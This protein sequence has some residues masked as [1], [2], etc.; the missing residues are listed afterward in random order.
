[1]SPRWKSE[2]ASE[3]YDDP[4]NGKRVSE[5]DESGLGYFV[6][7]VGTKAKFHLDSYISSY[8]AL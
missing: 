8:F 3:E 6:Y 7:T 1:M 2:Y 4:K 5:K